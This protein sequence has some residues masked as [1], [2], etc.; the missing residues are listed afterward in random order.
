MKNRFIVG[1]KYSC[2]QEESK[3]RIM[4]FIC[5]SVWNIIMDARRL[6]VKRKSNCQ[7]PFQMKNCHEIYATI[8]ALFLSVS[9][10]PF[11]NL[12]IS[13]SYFIFRSFRSVPQMLC[14]NVSLCF[15][16]LFRIVHICSLLQMCGVFIIVST[17][18]N[19]FVLPDSSFLTV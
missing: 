15:A 5:L 4:I 10:L 3:K 9:L 7:N 1:K 14:R 16:N 13:L 6:S 18:D 8:C 2:T 11:F 17:V 19:F 12:R